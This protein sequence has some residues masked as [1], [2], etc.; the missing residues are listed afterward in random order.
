M[1]TDLFFLLLG[2]SVTV[3]LLSCESATGDDVGSPGVVT[4]L[5]VSESPSCT[6]LAEIQ[7][8][9]SIP[10]RIRTVVRHAERP[11]RLVPGTALSTSHSFLVTEMRAQ[12]TYELEFTIEDEQGH[13]LEQHSRS[14]KTGELP[15]QT[16]S[17]M[18]SSTLEDDGNLFLLGP[19]PKSASRVESAD[20]PLVLAVD[21]DGEVVWYLQN[22]GITTAFAP[23]DVRLRDDGNLVVLVPG[24]WNLFTLSGEVVKKYR[25]PR[26]D[27]YFH[28]DVIDLPMGGFATLAGSV[29]SLNVPGLGS[30]INIRGDQI[31]ELNE[32]GEIIWEWSTFDHLDTTR[33]P[34][35]LALNPFYIGIGEPVYD[36]THA[37]AVVYVEDEDAYLL[38]LRH[39]SWVV[40]LDRAT[41]E[42]IWRLG[43]DGDFALVDGEGG[44][45]EWFYNQHNPFLSSDGVLTL[46]DNGNE[47]PGVTEPYSRAVSYLLD[48]TNMT[49]TQIWSYPVGFYSNFLGGVEKTA[50]GRWLVTAGGNRGSESPG[51]LAEVP[52]VQGVESEWTLSYPDSVVYRAHQ[53]PSLYV[54]TN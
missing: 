27:L 48:E 8:E 29:R 47:R 13:V 7:V 49:A 44:A 41:G 21:R 19:A 25:S 30:Q 35:P 20:E 11:Q 17:E 37:N 52:A 22:P 24:G 14:F 16:A 40:K 54:D 53:V 3:P 2:V 42:V 10:T 39:Q 38:S 45:A 34:G 50:A 9:T 32:D 23:R 33:F 28:H 31:I 43:P 12:S 36:W 46:Y 6:L 1:R 15:T 5:D 26:E 4:V 51:Q 18:L